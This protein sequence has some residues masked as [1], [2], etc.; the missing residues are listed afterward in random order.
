MA[1][2]TSGKRIQEKE[3]KKKKIKISFPNGRT[4]LS[5]KIFLQAL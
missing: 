4:I 3:F 5:S 1:A 2:F